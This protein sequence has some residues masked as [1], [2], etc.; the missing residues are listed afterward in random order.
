MPVTMLSGYGGSSLSAICRSRCSLLNRPTINLDQAGKCAVK[1]H[2]TRRLPNPVIKGMK[3][4][5]LAAIVLSGCTVNYVLPPAP[6]QSVT[7]N[8]PV[9][10]TYTAPEPAPAP[11]PEPETVIQPSDDHY[12]RAWANVKAL[13]DDQAFVL[14]ATM[15]E[16]EEKYFTDEG[17]STDGMAQLAEDMKERGGNPCSPE[18]QVTEAR[19][20]PILKKAA[21]NPWQSND[22]PVST[23]AQADVNLMFT[24]G[25]LSYLAVHCDDPAPEPKKTKHKS[26]MSGQ[27]TI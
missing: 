25:L 1:F 15:I 18:D 7:P 13:N 9:T 20:A 12:R 16:N 3:K 2:R 8:Q 26:R 4:L 14:V 11:A 19:I 10:P 27:R 24:S 6:S 22:L 23:K 21:L 17:I 5:A